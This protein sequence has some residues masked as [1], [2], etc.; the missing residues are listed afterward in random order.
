M[1]HTQSFTLPEDHPSAAGHFPG[2]PIIP[3]AVLLDAIIAAATGEAPDVLVHNT[4][5]LR[6]VPHGTDL[7]LRWQ[8]AGGSKIRF[9]CRTGD[10][11]LV[12]SGMLTAGATP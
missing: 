12:L 10:D 3:G 11:A 8:E 6:P 1:W 4:K 9:E 7:Q 2:N 5:F